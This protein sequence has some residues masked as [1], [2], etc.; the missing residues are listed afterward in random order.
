MVVLRGTTT[1]WYRARRAQYRV[2]PQHYHYTPPPRTTHV[3]PRTSDVMLHIMHA[4]SED[5]THDLG[6]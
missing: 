4:E 2:R 3:V 6:L 5:R 1:W